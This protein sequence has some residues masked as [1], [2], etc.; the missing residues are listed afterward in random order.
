MIHLNDE[1]VAWEPGLTLATLLARQGYAAPTVAVWLNDE[2]VA[3]GSY[4]QTPVPDD[5]SVI[6]VLMA[7]GG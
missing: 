6:V 5:A 2:F 4:E 7:P 1:P 3:R